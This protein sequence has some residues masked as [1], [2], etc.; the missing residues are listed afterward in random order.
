MHSIL[1]QR[2]VITL[3]SAPKLPMEM[4]QMIAQELNAMD[5]MN[6][7]LKELKCACSTVRARQRTS[8]TVMPGMFIK[9][10]LIIG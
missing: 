3:F 7:T 9:C 4:A 10:H 5:T 6:T 2:D 1:L 8:Y